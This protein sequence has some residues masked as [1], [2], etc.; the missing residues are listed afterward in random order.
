[1]NNIN[2]QQNLEQVLWVEIK[3]S[4]SFPATR[5]LLAHYTS[6]ATFEQI[7]S[8]NEIWLSN[9]LYMN[10]W[11]E[12]QF[13]MIEGAKA[14]RGNKNI[15]N[16]CENSN[17]YN[18]LINAFDYLFN[19]FDIRHVLDTYVLCFSEHT[20]DRA[21]GLLSM[22]RGYGANGKGIAIVF[23][24]K[25]I[26]PLPNSP[27]IISK[28]HYGSSQERIEWMNLKTSQLAS[29]LKNYP[30]TDEN[31][32]YISHAWF[33]RLKIFSLFTKHCG[34][35]EEQEWR[36]VYLNDRD[37]NQSL[38]DMLSYSITQK[39]VEPK[40]KLKIDSISGVTGQNISLEN[41]ISQI[42]LGPSISTVLTRN[43]I[44][45]MLELKGKNILAEKVL[46][47]SIPYRA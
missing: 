7:I 5:P 25:K 21:D 43:S 32:Y 8:N 2:I 14:F 22:W 1:M 28:V 13:G 12:L 20:T 41:L 31:L 23:D 44:C 33:Q 26:E 37:S 46:V 38:K 42:I 24:L 27:L 9:P 11:E 30:Q 6:I 34:F 4:P 10:D 45:R 40:L 18:K 3:D 16:A 47:S 36:I 29:I 39:G 19:E 17:A 15:L 35:N